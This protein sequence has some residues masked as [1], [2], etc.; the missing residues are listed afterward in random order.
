MWSQDDSG[1]KKPEEVTCPTSAQS[2]VSSEVRPSFSGLDTVVPW[3][4]QGW[5]LQ[6]FSGKLSHCLIVLL[7]KTFFYISSQNLSVVSHSPTMHLCEWRPWP[8]LLDDLPIDSGKLL[9]GASK[10]ISSP[11]WIKPLSSACPLREV[12][13]TPASLED[14][15]WT[16]PSWASSFFY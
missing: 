16:N 8:C 10:T 2:K 9:L 15:C 13:Q 6:I 3:N 4:P 1:W 14:L 12:L 5:R 11:G 7:G